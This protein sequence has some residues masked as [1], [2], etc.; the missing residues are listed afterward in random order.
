M[1]VCDD[2]RTTLVGDM[3]QV[4]PEGATVAARLTVPV[5]PLRDEVVI[6]EVVFE[7]AIDVRLAGFAFMLKS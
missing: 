5:K 3:L 1:E 4:S 6:V 7:P 2:P